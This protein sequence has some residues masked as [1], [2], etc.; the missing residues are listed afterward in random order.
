MSEQA[1]NSSWLA[2]SQISSSSLMGCSQELFY[3]ILTIDE[4]WRC[5]FDILFS[6]M[7]FLLSKA[8]SFAANSSK[9]TGSSFFGNCK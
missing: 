2:L 1:Q 8:S 6:N 4:F 3:I 5:D 7:L 9:F